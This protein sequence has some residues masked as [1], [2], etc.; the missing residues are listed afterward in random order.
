MLTYRMEV[1]FILEQHTAVSL[2]YHIIFS[3]PLGVYVVRLLWNIAVVHKS[4][5]RPNWS[6][7]WTIVDI[8][9][10]L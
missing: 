7:R 9:T 4:I 6:E 5:Y 10:T 8:Q 3:V 1:D 2:L